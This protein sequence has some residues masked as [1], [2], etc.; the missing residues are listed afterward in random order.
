M[1]LDWPGFL[2]RFTQRWRINQWA[3]SL[4]LVLA[5][6]PMA[7]AHGTRMPT[8][9][10]LFFLHR[11]ACVNNAVFELSGSQLAFCLSQM[12]K[13]P[14]MSL[15]LLPAGPL[16]GS[17]G[18]LAVAPFMLALTTF[19]LVIWLGWL[20]HRLQ[21]PFFATIALAAA[22]RLSQ[23][24]EAF[25]GGWFLVDG[26]YAILVA[27]ALLLPFIERELPT[28]PTRSAMARGLLWGGISA[29]GL[30]SKL[31]FAF[32]LVGI[33]PLTLLLSFRYS[34]LRATIV[35]LGVAG[36]ICI[37]PLVMFMEY[38]SLYLRIAWLSSYGGWA[39]FYN[40][41]MSLG[42]F[43]RRLAVEA[44]IDYKY[45]LLNVGI[46][47]VGLFGRRRDTGRLLLACAVGSLVL[48][49][50]AMVL[51]SANRE[52]RFLWPVWIALPLIAACLGAPRGGGTDRFLPAPAIVVAIIL[53]L[54]MLWLFDFQM[55]AKA[56]ALMQMLPRDRP[57]ILQIASDES[58]LN[59]ETFVLAK[60]VDR[61]ELASIYPTTVVYDLANGRTLDHSLRALREA[62]FV[63][64]R[65][66]V[67][68]PPAPEFS[69][70]FAAE[71]LKT[72]R[73]CGHYLLD[74]PGPPELIVAAM[75]C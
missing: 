28:S 34:G 18:Q 63:I 35:K 41:N 40:D 59:I 33:V 30:L 68:V 8:W 31:T 21:I 70:R 32:F 69:N 42:E 19:G 10:E 11:A 60:Q 2:A 29:S 52:L 9:D 1:I 25:N 65:S 58:A 39:E 74:E 61:Q 56:K 38:G 47:G 17:F 20:L 51:A 6:V 66:P 5:V 57:V 12:F 37:L 7:V 62:D 53:S 24:S 3:P 50:L 75:R 14:S 46:V 27:I 43:F 67:A 55:V 71:F 16:K 13:S 73:S 23:P 54:P 4:L 45:W 49:Y 15:L 48:V 26:A 64:L 22:I 36:T 44:G 72:V